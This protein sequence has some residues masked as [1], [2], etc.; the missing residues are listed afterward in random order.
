MSLIQNQD[1]NNE[2][3]DGANIQGEWTSGG[4]ATGA[5]TISLVFPDNF[6]TDVKL[7]TTTEDFRIK[8]ID[9]VSGDYCEYDKTSILGIDYSLSYPFGGGMIVTCLTAGLGTAIPNLT[10]G[11]ITIDVSGQTWL[12]DRTGW[13]YRRIDTQKQIDF[14]CDLFVL[15]RRSKPDATTLTAN[16]W[17]IGTTYAKNAWVYVT[18]TDKIY[19]SLQAGNVGNDPDATEGF[20]ALF[21]DKA[22]EFSWMREDIGRFLTVIPIDVNNYDDCTMFNPYPLSGGF[23][24]KN[25]WNVK[26]QSNAIAYTTGVLGKNY[27]VFYELPDFVWCSDNGQ[28]NEYNL[29]NVDIVSCRG[30]TAFAGVEGLVAGKSH[31]EIQYRGVSTSMSFGDVYSNNVFSDLDHPIWKDHAENNCIWGADS[32]VGGGYLVNNFIRRATRVKFQ[33][34]LTNSALWDFLECDFGTSNDGHIITCNQSNGVMYQHF[35]NYVRNIYINE[36]TSVLKKNTWGDGYNGVGIDFS[37]A[38]LIFG[39]YPKEIY[40][41]PDGTGKLKYMDNTDALVIALPTD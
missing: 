18:A 3:G 38:T 34:S 36:P 29:N 23:N 14:P 19:Y 26:I 15:Q 10:G 7:A 2:V 31:V 22:T 12:A 16:E 13:I 28:G 32:L 33:D 20:W 8:C 27:D 21:M 5:V 6:K 1:R 4:G 39:D 25:V 41:R 9:S 11:N 24:F 35:G 30:I 40:N 17:V 37:S